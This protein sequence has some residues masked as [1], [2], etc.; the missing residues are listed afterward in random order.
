MKVDKRSCKY[1]DMQKAQQFTTDY[2]LLDN[3]TE[4]QDAAYCAHRGSR[5]TSLPPRRQATPGP[6]PEPP[7]V[8]G[9][10]FHGI[11]PFLRGCKIMGLEAANDSPAIIR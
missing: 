4:I 8:P 7:P 9:G 6:P 3:S 1:K 11:A 5:A 2:W 10:L